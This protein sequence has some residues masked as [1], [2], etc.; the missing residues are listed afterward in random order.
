[1]FF[2][3]VPSTSCLSPFLCAVYTSNSQKA[4]SSPLQKVPFGCLSDNLC[5][6][7]L[8]DATLLLPD[9]VKDP[10]TISS[11]HLPHLNSVTKVYV[12]IYI[13]VYVYL[14]SI[15]AYIRFYLISSN[16]IILYDII[17][18]RVV[19]CGIATESSQ[20]LSDSI[21]PSRQMSHLLFLVSASGSG[22]ST[23]LSPPKQGLWGTFRCSCLEIHPGKLTAG[24]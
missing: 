14:K 11:D 24:T 20:A 12:Y 16:I 4:H 7:P 18:H 15:Y 17:I 3:S 10:Y 22:T 2:G 6:G 19:L 5:S 23:V 13:H 9:G 21:I 1:M 8:Q